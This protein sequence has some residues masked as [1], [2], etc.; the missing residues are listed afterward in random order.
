MYVDIELK[1]RLSKGDVLPGLF[2]EKLSS[3]GGRVCKM[4]T[5][6]SFN[7]V[8]LGAFKKLWRQAMERDPA[9]PDIPTAV[10][11]CVDD[12]LPWFLR[13]GFGRFIAGCDYLK[14]KHD[15]VSGF[16][17]WRWAALEKRPVVPWTVDD[18]GLAKKLL[19]AGCEG[20][21]TNKPVIIS[22]EE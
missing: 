15:Q 4:V 17:R 6:S 13:R 18:A 11:F 5:V 22:K 21:I 14:P 2:A 1:S 9:L 3:M 10:I 7:P 19:D 20:I 12:E 8:C 16:S